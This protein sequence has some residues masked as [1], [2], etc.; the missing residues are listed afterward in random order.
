MDIDPLQRLASFPEMN[1]HPVLEVDVKGNII[2]ANPAALAFLE[3][4]GLTNPATYLPD[5]IADILRRVE[6]GERGVV[7]REIALDER[8]FL[9][10][11][12]LTP[13]NQSA[14]IYCTE[15]TQRK[16]V[17]LQLQ[18]SLERL[19]GLRLISRAML[20]ARSPAEIVRIKR[21]FYWYKSLRSLLRRIAFMLN[22]GLVRWVSLL[23]KRRISSIYRSSVRSR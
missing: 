7:F 21:P 5:D 1:P 2:Y 18:Q 19:R 12:S 22:R 4:A 9:E 11:I 10:S 23:C 6:R 8:V 20:E 17:E 14:R 13:H 15:I 3:G 16:N